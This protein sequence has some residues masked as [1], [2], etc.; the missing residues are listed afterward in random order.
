MLYLQE[1]DTPGCY[2]YPEQSGIG[3]F[4][5]IF[6]YIQY[7]PEEILGQLFNQLT[8]RGVIPHTGSLTRLVIVTLWDIEKFKYLIEIITQIEIY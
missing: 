4:Y 6:V 3:G 8:R 1:I 5:F 7:Y 2:I